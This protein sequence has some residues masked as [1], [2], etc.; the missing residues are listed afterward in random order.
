MV[1]HVLSYSGKQEKYCS[2]PVV[3]FL[4]YSKLPLMSPPLQN[5]MVTSE[6]LRTYFLNSFPAASDVLVKGLVTREALIK[7]EAIAELDE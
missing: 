4:I 5:H 2:L 3:H 6:I 7:I 1:L